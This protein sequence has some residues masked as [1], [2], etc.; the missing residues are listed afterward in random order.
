MIYARNYT[1]LFIVFLYK[2]AERK[3]ELLLGTSL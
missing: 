2:K 3:K 1:D